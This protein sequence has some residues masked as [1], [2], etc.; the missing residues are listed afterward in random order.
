MVVLRGSVT[1]DPLTVTVPSSLPPPVYGLT[2]GRTG[3]PGVLSLQSFVGLGSWYYRSSTGPR[4]VVPP[5]TTTTSFVGLGI[6]ARR[7][8]R[9]LRVRPAPY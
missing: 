1:L 5:V 6:W 8:V 7:P 9:V 2:R 4:S 3:S